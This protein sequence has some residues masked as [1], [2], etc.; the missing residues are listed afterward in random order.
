MYEIG[1]DIV[2]IDRIDHMISRFGL[3]FLHRFLLPLEI[4]LVSKNPIIY[5][6]E[7]IYKDGDIAL[8]DKDRL[9]SIFIDSSNFTKDMYRLESIAGFWSAKE[10]FAKA[11]GFGIG[12]DVAFSDICIY[13]DKRGRPH[14]ALDRHKLAIWGLRKIS[15]SITH[16]NNIASA[17]CL[18]C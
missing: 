15:L 8:F 6:D 14:I 2:S 17:A 18:I 10:A 16:D 4:S 1:I 7:Y 5:D 3:R 11:L 13:K 12:S 9:L